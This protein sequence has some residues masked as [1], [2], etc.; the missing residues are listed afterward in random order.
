MHKKLAATPFPPSTLS[1]K[2]MSQEPP[3]QINYAASNVCVHFGQM[4]L[5]VHIVKCTLF[6]ILRYSLQVLLHFCCTFRLPR[7][8]VLAILI[9]YGYA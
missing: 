5:N 4:K 8:F 9:A 7:G 1:S 2:M 3:C 6:C